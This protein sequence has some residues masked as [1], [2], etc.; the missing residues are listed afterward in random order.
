MPT[1]WKTLRSGVE[2][3]HAGEAHAK[4]ARQLHTGDVTVRARAP[5]TNNSYPIAAVSEKFSAADTVGPT[6]RTIGPS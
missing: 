3:L 4:P 6:S 1:P 5:L 2:H